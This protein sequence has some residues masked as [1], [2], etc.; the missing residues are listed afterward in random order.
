MRLIRYRTQI[1]HLYITRFFQRDLK[2]GYINVFYLTQ[3]DEFAKEIKELTK[4]I[5]DLNISFSLS[6]FLYCLDS[7]LMS[8][9][10][11]RPRTTVPLNFL[12]LNVHSRKGL[13]L[14]AAF[15]A[16]TKVKSSFEWN[17]MRSR[18]IIAPIVDCQSEYAFTK[19]CTRV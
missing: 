18:E 11:V 16:R 3:K 15:Y 6:S 4:N 19:R 9:T 2:Y 12:S 7:S 14:K 1:C 17:V 5:S 10:N 8:R 13:V